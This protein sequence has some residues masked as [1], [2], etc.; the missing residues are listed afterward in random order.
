MPVRTLT[1]YSHNESCL[2][3]ELLGKEKVARPK[4][5]QEHFDGL[6]SSIT[7]ARPAIL[8]DFAA[9]KTMEEVK[10]L[11]NQSIA[12]KQAAQNAE[13]AKLKQWEERRARGYESHRGP[14][15][16]RL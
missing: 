2:E 6:V 7:A 12:A 10:V 1:L 5:A 4:Q 14:R 13:A 11:C 9:V 8:K 3:T 15:V 16:Q